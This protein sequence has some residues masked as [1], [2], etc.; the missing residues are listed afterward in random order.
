MIDVMPE[1]L[2]DLDAVGG[3]PASPAAE[4]ADVL[5]GVNEQL[6]ARLAGRAREGV[7]VPKSRSRHATCTYSCRRP[8]SR[9][10]RNGWMEAPERGGVW[11]AGGCWCRDRCGRWLL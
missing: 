10:R 8:P 4:A 5:G 11:P 2:V 9:S 6:I 1:P 7:W 3:E